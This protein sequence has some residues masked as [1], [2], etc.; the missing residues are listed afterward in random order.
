MKKSANNPFER[1][2]FDATLTANRLR[3]AGAVR[4]ERRRAQIPAYES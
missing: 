4:H 2:A 3:L 1:A